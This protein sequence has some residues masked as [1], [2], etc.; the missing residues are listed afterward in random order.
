M[1]KNVLD[2]TDKCLFNHL[3]TREAQPADAPPPA[4]IPDP[5]SAEAVPTPRRL[6]A[7]RGPPIARWR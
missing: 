3:Q 6:R 7:R 2:M 1:A 5:E 4:R